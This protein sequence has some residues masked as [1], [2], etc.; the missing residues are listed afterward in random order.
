MCCAAGLFLTRPDDFF[1]VLLD[2][3][4]GQHDLAAAAR[5][6]DLE[7]HAHPQHLEAGRSA[8][9]LFAGEDGISNCD[10]HEQLS[11]LPVPA[12]ARIAARADFESA[13]AYRYSI[14]QTRIKCN[15]QRIWF[16]CRRAKRR[17]RKTKTA[18]KEE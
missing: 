3:C 14:I 15:C 4:P 7:I 2:L 5:A 17:V 12:Q 16:Y 13:A 18:Q 6:A 8:G 1:D 11:L 10:I 9:V